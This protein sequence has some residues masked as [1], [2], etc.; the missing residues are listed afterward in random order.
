MYN[1]TASDTNFLLGPRVIV[2]QRNLKIYPD[3]VV[4]MII[5]FLLMGCSSSPKYY[6]NPYEDP[7]AQKEYQEWVAGHSKKQERSDEF[8]KKQ[9]AWMQTD[10]ERGPIYRG[11]ME[12]ITHVN[13]RWQ[14]IQNK[15][16]AARLR[17]F[18]QAVGIFSSADEIKSQKGRNVQE[19]KTS[20][21]TAANRENSARYQK[22][23]LLRQ[24]IN[25][26]LYETFE[27]EETDF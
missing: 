26:R 3:F 6:N 18:R 9:K 1:L 16:K 7:R 20:I 8:V 4:L 10:E 24:S 17:A 5:G 12:D 13:Q 23:L 27:L 21:D 25:N 11:Y 14:A 15:D 2:F 22:Y 19:R